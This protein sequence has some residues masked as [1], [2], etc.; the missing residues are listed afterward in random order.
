MMKMK[1]RIQR[2][3][4]LQYTVLNGK[5]EYRAL[6]DQVQG[7][8]SIQDSNRL[9]ASFTNGKFYGVQPEKAAAG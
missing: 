9:T 1:H 6:T 5:V 7:N 3:M 2:A 8:V 4:I